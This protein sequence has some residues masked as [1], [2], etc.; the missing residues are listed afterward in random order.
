M[1]TKDTF[2]PEIQPKDIMI[3]QAVKAYEK[4]FAKQSKTNVKCFWK[5]VNSKLKRPTGI[6][7]LLKLDGTMTINDN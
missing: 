5:Y 2:L 6:C 4:N 3:P 1:I 7:N